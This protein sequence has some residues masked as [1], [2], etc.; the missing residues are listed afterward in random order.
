LGRSFCD[1]VAESSDR[2]YCFHI[3]SKL[4]VVISGFSMLVTMA[5]LLRLLLASTLVTAASAQ[6]C[7]VCGEGGTVGNPNGVLQLPAN[8]FGLTQAS[9]AQILQAGLLGYL[10]PEVCSER[11]RCVRRGLVENEAKVLVVVER[12]LTIC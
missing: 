4:L 8:E 7:H 12:L 3:F 11:D 1:F 5:R 9:C 6:V 10:P 2:S